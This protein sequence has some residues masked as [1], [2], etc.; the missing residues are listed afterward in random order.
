MQHHG[1]TL[2]LHDRSNL[3]AR[4]CLPVCGRSEPRSAGCGLSP[5]ASSPL[6]AVAFGCHAWSCWW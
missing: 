5:R 4:S 6:A 3:N 1:S 2:D